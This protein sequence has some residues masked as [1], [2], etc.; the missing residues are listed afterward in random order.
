[1]IK[2]IQLN[3]AMFKKLFEKIFGLNMTGPA[4]ELMVASVI[5]NFGVGM[6][7]LF[8]PIYLYQ[9]GFG[10]PSILLFY[11]GVYLIYFVLLP[12][13]GKFAQRFGYEHA[14]F[15]SIPFWILY[16]GALA[17]VGLTPWMIYAAMLMLALSKTLYWPG[18][19][20]EFSRYGENFER[21]REISG[22]LVVEN[23]A[24]IL[25]PLIGG[26][27]LT[28][29]NFQVLFFVASIIMI[30]STLPL[31]I[32]AET[33]LP[34]FFPYFEMF[35]LIIDKRLSPFVITNIGFG[36]DFF[37][38]V[39]WPMFIY[40][41]LSQST[42]FTGALVSVSTLVM[43]V[44]F[45]YIGRLDDRIGARAILKIGTIITFFVWLM[46]VFIKMPL[47]VFAADSLGRISRGLIYI[48]LIGM[49]YEYGRKN[50]VM[51][52]AVILEMSLSLGKMI[53]IAL[54][55]FLFMALPSATAWQGIFVV[56]AIFALLYG[57]GKHIP[58]L[59]MPPMSVDVPKGNPYFRENIHNKS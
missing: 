47:S 15:Y 18:Y 11:F 12:L 27:I 5:L 32:T 51:R 48:P 42:F 7:Q 17:F 19:H 14:I 38:L 23:L 31:M 54:S 55:W 37:T 9:K 39:M 10:I 43:A 36:E 45:L 44:A 28:V 46:R 50:A 4:T 52:T 57:F 20:G 8:E 40:L 34:K 29:A 53:T 24:M 58:F 22:V 21:G 1:M 13:G 25:G 41:A 56:A 16:F 49:V 35:K 3:K 2:M 33:F 26:I 59:H 6:V 30:L